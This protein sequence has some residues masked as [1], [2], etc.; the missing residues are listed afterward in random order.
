[1]GKPTPPPP[2]PPPPPGPPLGLNLSEGLGLT[3]YGCVLRL[4]VGSRGPALCCKVDDVRDRILDVRVGVWVCQSRSEPPLQFTICL[5]DAWFCSQE[6]ADEQRVALV[7]P[8]SLP[9]VNVGPTGARLLHE[10]ELAPVLFARRK[11]EAR[12]LA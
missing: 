7:G 4:P 12:G 2:P 10:E 11:A 5:C 6:V 1:M 8:S 3:W 9:D